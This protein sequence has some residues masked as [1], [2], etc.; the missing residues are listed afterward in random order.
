MAN[1][2]LGQTG[3]TVERN[4]F[5]ALPIQRVSMAE[6]SAI[7]R[8]AFAGGIRFYDTARAYSDSEQK[9][10]AV[11]GEPGMREQIFLATKTHAKTPEEFWEHL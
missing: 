6:A 10:G 2:T 5:G 9:L 11:F 8:R 4:G 3:I 7:L 1:V